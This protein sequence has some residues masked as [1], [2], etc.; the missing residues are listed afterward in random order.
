VSEKKG[1]KKCILLTFVK[2]VFMEDKLQ[3]MSRASLITEMHLAKDMV[4]RI[5]EVRV[6]AICKTDKRQ[7]PDVID[8]IDYFTNFPFDW[9][10][11]IKVLLSD[12]SDQYEETLKNIQNEL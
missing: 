8:L 1:T 9:S 4:N 2:V 11:E 5:T 7:Q 10:R 6:Y 12:A 3:N